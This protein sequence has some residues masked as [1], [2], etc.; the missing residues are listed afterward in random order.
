MLLRIFRL[1]EPHRIS[2]YKRYKSSSSEESLRKFKV[3][4]C[5]AAGGIGQSLSLMLKQSP[6]IQELALYD[7]T[8]T[9]GVSMDISH[10]NTKCKVAGYIGPNEFVHALK[11]SYV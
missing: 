5:G 6:L 10:V 1:F 3:A 8:N 2:V 9:R 4:I 7:I 11:V